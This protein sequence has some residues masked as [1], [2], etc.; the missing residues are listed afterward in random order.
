[1]RDLVMEFFKDDTLELEPKLNHV[2]FHVPVELCMVESPH[3]SMQACFERPFPWVKHS[4]LSFA[5]SLLS[6]IM[7]WH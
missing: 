6:D 3:P 4:L 1:M 7:T 5:S 2:K